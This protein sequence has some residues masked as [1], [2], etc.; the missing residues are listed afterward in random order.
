M[1]ANCAV[2][3]LATRTPPC[4]TNVS[5]FANPLQPSPGRMS[6]VWAYVPMLGVSGF[7]DDERELKLKFGNELKGLEAKAYV[8]REEG[9]TKVRM[10]FDDMKKVPANKQFTLW[11]ASPD[12]TYTKLGQVINSG[13][14]DE[15]EIKAETA[16]QD[17]GLFITA[18][19]A[20]VATPTSKV[21]S[22]F[23]IPATTTNPK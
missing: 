14:A 13:K 20:D 9:K 3:S 19:E 5:R 6:S 22:V 23:S 8:D 4:F 15:A 17:F 2:F 11:A 21:Y 18:E 1:I 12:G 10:H 16:L 7:G